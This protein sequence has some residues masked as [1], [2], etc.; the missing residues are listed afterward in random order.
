MTWDVLQSS[1]SDE[2]PTPQPLFDAL[3]RVFGFTLDVCATP[4]NAKCQRFYTREQD[5]LAQPWNGTV[6]CNP[7]YGRNITGKWMRK[8]WEA[9]QEGA[10]VVCLV[11]ARTD[12]RWWHDWISRAVDVLLWRGRL[13][14]GDAESGAPFASALVTFSSASVTPKR[15]R[16]CVACDG[17]FAASRAD[18]TTCSGACRVALHRSDR[19]AAA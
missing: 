9:S 15:L 8:A 11:P 14:F 13:K 1:A 16:Q 10:T 12:T 7:P 2:W 4:A 5:G 18:A 6:W 17:V 3:D 19:K